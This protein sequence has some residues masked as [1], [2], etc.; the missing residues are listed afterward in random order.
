MNAHVQVGSEI[1]GYRVEAELGRGGMGVVYLAE[2]LTLGRKVALKV[3]APAFSSDPEFRQR[4]EREARAAASLDHPN[5]V[6]VFE[7]DDHDGLLF[8]AMRF[9]RGTD[10]A[11]VLAEQGRL[12]PF[13]AANVTRQIAGALDEAHRHGLIHR[14]VKPANVLVTDPTPEGHVY[15]TD[16]GLAKNAAVN[17]AGLT[18]SGQFVGTIDYIAPEQLDGRAIDARTDVYSLGC[19]LFQLLAGRVPFSGNQVQKM[20][21]HANEEPPS[22]RDVAAHLAERFDP[23]VARAMAKDPDQRYLS[24]GD[25]GRAAMAAAAEEPASLTEKSVAVGPATGAVDSLAVRL[26]SDSSAS[27]RT[28]ATAAWKGTSAAPGPVPWQAPTAAAP[29]DPRRTR[30]SFVLPGVAA[31]LVAAGIAGGALLASRGGDSSPEPTASKAEAQRSNATEPN[32]GRQS[33]ERS[34][35]ATKERAERTTDASAASTPPPAPVTYRSYTPSTRGYSAQVPTGSGWSEPVESQPNPGKLY[36]T[37]ITGPDGLVLLI[38]YTPLEPA[39][40]GGKYTSTRTLRH[41]AFGTATEYV[42][43]GGA[44]DACADATCVDYLVN[45]T[46]RGSGYGV[47]AGG[48]SDVALTKRVAHRVAQSLVYNDL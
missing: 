32:A 31:I 22:L 42:F 24:A 34:K 16:F 47:L 18:N 14:D 46:E 43:T 3:I 27:T 8:L 6:P 13:H 7:A 12:E 15:L 17:S 10:L 1:R 39:R 36:R 35:P 11:S 25:L 21:G 5:I 48:S 4:F 29:Q 30:R 20:W 19:V 26:P 45:D 23:V 44:L 9:V 37:T 28:A 40:F 41:P 33:S 2:Q 38:D